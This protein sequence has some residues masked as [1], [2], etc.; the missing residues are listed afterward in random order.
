[1]RDKKDESVASHEKR[2]ID[3]QIALVTVITHRETNLCDG[4]SGV[5]SVRMVC[6]PQEAEEETGVGRNPPAEGVARRGVNPVDSIRESRQKIPLEGVWMERREDS[7]L[8]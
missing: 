6:P 2:S 1:M 4:P 3:Q 5:M 7:V 8:V